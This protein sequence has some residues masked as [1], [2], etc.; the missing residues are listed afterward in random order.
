MIGCSV[1]SCILVYVFV[2]A[3]GR[4]YAFTSVRAHIHTKVCTCVYMHIF[5][6]RW[7]QKTVNIHMYMHTCINPYIYTHIHAYFV[8]VYV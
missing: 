8:Y 1:L 3:H 5:M 2:L 7:T 6:L 4:V